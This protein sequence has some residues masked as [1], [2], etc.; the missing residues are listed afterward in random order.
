MSKIEVQ[1]FSE[2]APHYFQYITKAYEA[3]VSQF[4]S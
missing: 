3:G 1:S 2:F 4:I